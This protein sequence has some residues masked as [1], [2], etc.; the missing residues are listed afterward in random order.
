VYVESLLSPSRKRI[1]DRRK[2]GEIPRLT[3]IIK[4]HLKINKDH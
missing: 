1:R 2:R 4:E 3:K